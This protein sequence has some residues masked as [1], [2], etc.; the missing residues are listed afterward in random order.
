M[1]QSSYVYIL[2]MVIFVAGMWL[3]IEW[4]TTMLHPCEDLAGQW[5][6]TPEQAT[7]SANPTRMQVEQSGRYF[8]ITLPDTQPL[9]MKMTHETVV[10]QHF[11]E[12]KRIV[13]AGDGAKASFLGRTGGDLWRLDFDGDVKG[14]FIA[15]LTDRTYP[16]PEPATRPAASY[17]AHAR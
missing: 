12:H 13:L 14:S 8:R 4:G 5:E 17:S 11:G 10:D 3:I 2:A 6:L 7:A 16:K 9:Q 15:H 1:N